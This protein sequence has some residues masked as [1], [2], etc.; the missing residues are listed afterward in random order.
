MSEPIKIGVLGFA[1]G[2]V[3]TYCDE[4][5]NPE[6]GIQVAAGWDHDPERLEKAKQAIGLQT[7]ADAAALLPDIAFR[8]RWL[9]R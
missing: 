5:K 3:N 4:W 2:H 8:S 1:H 6:H 9:G 7:Y